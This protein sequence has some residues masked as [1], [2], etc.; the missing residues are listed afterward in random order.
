LS[1]NIRQP[2]NR[3]ETGDPTGLLPAALR[4][5]RQ[6]ASSNSDETWNP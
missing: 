2:F 6:K 4:D 1:L 3:A 5:H